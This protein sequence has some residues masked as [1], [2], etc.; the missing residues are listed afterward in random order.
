MT[1]LH[2]L[3]L[4]NACSLETWSQRPINLVRDSEQA[5]RFQLCSESAYQPLLW[6]GLCAL[7][8]FLFSKF[9]KSFALESHGWN[10]SFLRFGLNCLSSNAFTADSM[11]Q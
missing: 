6:T 10:Y 4:F 2:K 5:H 3:E 7:E 9:S 8:N 11:G 1:F